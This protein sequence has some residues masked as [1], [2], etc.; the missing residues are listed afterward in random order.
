MANKHMKSHS[1]SLL[2]RELQ[3]KTLVSYHCIP[4]RALVRKI[5]ARKQ[6]I[7]IDEDVEKLEPW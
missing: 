4:I 3:V 6:K 7:N 5:K 1:I 2:V